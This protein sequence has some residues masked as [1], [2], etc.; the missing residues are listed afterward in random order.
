MNLFQSDEYKGA[1]LTIVAAI[2][3]LGA[4]I[5]PSWQWALGSVAMFQVYWIVGLSAGNHRYFTHRAFETSRFWEE[6]MI[7]AACAA[8]SGPPGVYALVHLEHHRLS[9]TPEDPHLYYMEKG[10]ISFKKINVRMSPQMKRRFV[11]DP[12]M[13]RTYRYYFV[14]PIVTALLFLAISPEAL[15]YLW[16]IPLIAMQ[17]FRKWATL[18]WIHQYGYVS[19]ETGDQSKNS[20][21]LSW[22]FGGEGLHNNHHR[23]PQ[24]WNFAMGQGE[25]DPGSWFVRLIK[26]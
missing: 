9:D 17:L 12:L 2:L 19:F 14:Y 26:N 13:M 16:A 10:L 24:R 1:L 11:A 8:H 18:K 7:W 25:V 3:C 4:L 23:Y 20:K 22:L 5:M 6:V 21:L 15:V